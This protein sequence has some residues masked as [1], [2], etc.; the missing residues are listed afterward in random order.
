MALCSGVPIFLLVNGDYD[1]SARSFSLEIDSRRWT[2]P[3]E[4]AEHGDS[5]F[6]NDP[7]F[8]DYFAQAKYRIAYRVGTWQ[9][10]FAPGPMLGRLIKECRS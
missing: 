3:S 8:T 6:I 1:R 2:L 10:A 9:V 7:K 5:L 4:P